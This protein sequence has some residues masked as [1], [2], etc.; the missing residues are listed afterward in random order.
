MKKIIIVIVIMVAVLVAAFFALNSYIYNDGREVV[1]KKPE[2]FTLTFGNDGKF[3]AT[4]DCN[5]MGGS[6][7]AKNDTIS[8]GE[9]YSTLMFCTDSQETEFS[10]LLGNIGGYHFT[11]RGELIFNLKFDSGTVV[12][13]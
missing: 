7:T 12:F 1:P 8:F 2:A 4:T 10:Q 13:R 9:M 3:S 5:S 6:Y 11:S